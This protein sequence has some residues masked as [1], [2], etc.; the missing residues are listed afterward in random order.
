MREVKIAILG[1]GTVGGG[2]YRLIEQ[3]RE[4]IMKTEGIKLTVAKTLALN[5]SVEV[6][7]EIKA[8]DIDE[9][10]NDDEIE[11]V[12]EVMGGV[13][14][15]KEFELKALRAGKTVV[16]AN[17]DMI[18]QYWPELQQ[19][20]E[21]SGAG[22]YFEAAVGG[23]IPILRAL[24]D[25][26]QANTINMVYGIVN[27]TTNYILTKMYEDGGDFAEV[28]K[29]AQELGYAEADPTSDIGGYDARYKLSILASMAFHA[30]IP[31]D[32]IYREGI[33]N[34]SGLDIEIAKEMGYVVKLL[35]I[36][37]RDENGEIEVRVHPTLIPG[38]HALAGIKGSFN[39]IFID[40]SAVGEMMWYGKGAG[41]LPTAS[42][43]ISDML[44]AVR[45]NEHR[46]AT[47]DNTYE[48]DKVKI[49]DNW[50]TE[51]YIRTTVL[52]Q[53]GVLAKIAGILGRHNV[54][55]QS[56]LQK[57]GK[58]ENFA[59]LILVTHE[60]KE[61]DLEKAVAEVAAL[62]EIAEKPQVIRVEK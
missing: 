18:S 28:L 40:G 29:E 39:A 10:I 5:Y 53:P 37:K 38:D 48:A 21:K 35:A 14:P 49:N 51:Y 46:Y 58:G 16:S 52:D 22:F 3:E 32:K 31:V 60:A 12:A 6:P 27:G 47:F 1:M 26:M 30:R 15:A 7:E 34:I 43:L 36:G 33:E 56:V 62:S 55:I 61:K 24:N 19:A 11:I 45:Q 42:A 25:S 17:K 9:I 8:K 23:A 54:S 20:A 2:I 4:Q 13:N 41:D 44:Y 59:P 57:P 50:T